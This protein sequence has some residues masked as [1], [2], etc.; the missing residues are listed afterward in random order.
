MT[1]TPP[2]RDD[3]QKLNNLS[4]VTK[5][6]LGVA[7][8]IPSSWFKKTVFNLLGSHIG[9]NVYFGP[10]SMLISNDFKNITIEDDT[11]VA[12]G[13]MLYVNHL[14]IG[15]HSTIGYQCLFVGDHMS[16]GSDCNI[17]NRSFIESSYAPV[18]IGNSVTIGASA[19]ISSHDGAYRQTFGL[20]MKKKPI[21][22]KNGAFIG[23]NAI[24][25]PGIEI[26][27]RAIVGAGAVVT[28]S[29]ES[30]VVV[31]GVPARLIEKRLDDKD[32]N[33]IVTE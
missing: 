8:Y 20:Q 14:I 12:P 22:I 31:A 6:L 33:E 13:V 19:I 4:F 24:I 9:K 5:I 28:K 27:E 10:G 11:F 17:S 23:N 15:A 1:L 3:R 25:L 2:L 26:G 29:V 30:G 18:S 21:S 32:K 16:I 7:L